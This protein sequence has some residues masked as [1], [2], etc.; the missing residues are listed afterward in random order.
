MTSC[1]VFTG[2]REENVNKVLVSTLYRLFLPLRSLSNN[3]DD[4][5]N[6]SKS[7]GLNWQNKTLHV[8]AYLYIY[9]PLLHGHDVK[10]PNFTF[11]GVREHKTTIFF[12]KLDTVL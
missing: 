11:S 10:L 3:D 1:T 8:D 4:I 6:G 2:L 12:F 7:M 9:L 5:E